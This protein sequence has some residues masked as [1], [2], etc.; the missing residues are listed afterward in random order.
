MAYKYIVYESYKMSLTIIPNETM[1]GIYQLLSPDDKIRFA[2]TC[3]VFRSFEPVG[4]STWLCKQRT[5]SAVIKQMYYN[6]DANDTRS[7]RKYLGCTTGYRLYPDGAL[8]IC[9]GF[10]PGVATSA[11]TRRYNSITSIKRI[12]VT[13]A[14]STLANKNILTQIHTTCDDFIDNNTDKIR[15]FM[16]ICN[17]WVEAI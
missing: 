14:L 8:S 11:Q 4:F 15:V 1:Y 5:V 17:I 6:I 2:A 16:E 12:N 7:N 13:S 10:A 3:K 9:Q